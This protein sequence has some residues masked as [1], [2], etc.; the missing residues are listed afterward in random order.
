[1]KINAVLLVATTIFMSTNLFAG[2]SKAP[3]KDPSHF[4]GS[5]GN[6][7]EG[8]K[9]VLENETMGCPQTFSISSYTYENG[10]TDLVLTNQFIGRMVSFP[11]VNAGK[12][13]RGSNFRESYTSSRSLALRKGY[14]YWH[15]GTPGNPE[16]PHQPPQL[17][18]V[19]EFGFDVM[20]KGD[21][22]ELSSNFYRSKCVYKK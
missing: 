5:Y 21:T 13:R 2:G 12:I 7:V 18:T 6:L 16:N 9:L 14:E 20:M 15:H 8:T 22:V 19:L 1:M 4:V 3:S 17:V 11:A 10:K